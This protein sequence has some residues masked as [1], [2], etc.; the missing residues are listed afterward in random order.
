[1]RCD[2]SVPRGDVS[3]ES[4]GHATCDPARQSSR[5]FDQTAERPFSAPPIPPVAL[6]PWPAN[7]TGHGLGIAGIVLLILL[8]KAPRLVRMLFPPERRQPPAV[9]AH[10]NDEQWGELKQMLE[11]ARRKQAVRHDQKAG[12]RQDAAPADAGKIEKAGKRCEA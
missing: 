4:T 2:L 12:S 3:S 1:V 8:A 11:E 7:R 6:V 9:P 5:P 10:V